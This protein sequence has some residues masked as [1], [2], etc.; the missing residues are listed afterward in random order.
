MSG[1]SFVLSDL[2]SLRRFR[3]VAEAVV[4]ARGGM[5]SETYLLLER[6]AAE[7]EVHPLD[8]DELVERISSINSNHSNEGHS[9]SVLVPGIDVIKDISNCLKWSRL[10]DLGHGEVSLQQAEEII[11][12]MNNQSFAGVSTWRIPQL[13]EFEGLVNSVGN[14][15]KQSAQSTENAVELLMRTGF[16]SVMSEWYWTATTHEHPDYSMIFDAGRGLSGYGNCANRYWL[17]AVSCFES[18]P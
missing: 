17:W 4:E 12:N 14:C 9:I 13:K 3:E 16:V 5:D 8:F 7:Y 6:K 1:V 18:K 10:A 11:S 15:I 2:D